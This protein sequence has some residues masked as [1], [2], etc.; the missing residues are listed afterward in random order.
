M[1]QMKGAGYVVETVTR[2]AVP[3][4]VGAGAVYLVV[5]AYVLRSGVLGVGWT[6]TFQGIFMMLLAWGLGLY[7]PHRLYGGVPEMFDGIAASRPRPPRPSLDSRRR[8]RH[9]GLGRVRKRSAREHRGREFL[10]SPLHEGLHGQGRPH[11]PPHGGALPDLSALPRSP[12]PHRL[13]RHPLRRPPARRR[14]DPAAH[15]DEYGPALARGGPVLRGR[16]RREHVLG[17]RHCPRR[18][19]HRG[20]RRLDDD[21]PPQPHPRSASAPPSAPS[22]C[23]SSSSPTCSPSATRAA[24]SSCSSAHMEPSSSSPP[25]SLWPSSGPAPAARWSST[26]LLAGVVATTVFVLYPDCAP[27]ARACRPLR[28]RRQ[29]RRPGTGVI[30]GGGKAVS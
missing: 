12:P 20:A 9:L 13:C 27:L 28:P 17:R 22:S 24:S 23:S 3:S 14:P 30:L 10:A 5:L 11:H 6:N 21:G 18:G 29:P 15:A 16:P 26:A 2:G 4:W 19:L 1:L 25:R 7:L 8:W